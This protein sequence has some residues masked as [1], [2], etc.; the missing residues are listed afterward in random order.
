MDAIYAPDGVK[1]GDTTSAAIDRLSAACSS[2]A[3]RGVDVIVPGFTELSLVLPVLASRMSCP[4]L[5]ANQCSA[6][7]VVA[8]SHVLRF[9]VHPSHGGL[10][11]RPEP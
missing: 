6:P 8:A 5:D 11:W 10:T 7:A 9:A 4:T 3:S 2:L 1:S